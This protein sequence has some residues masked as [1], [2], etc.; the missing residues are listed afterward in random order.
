MAGCEGPRHRRRSR[1]SW[2]NTHHLVNQTISSANAPSAVPSAG[3]S[4]LSCTLSSANH[5]P[6]AP[7][8]MASTLGFSASA[9]ASASSAASSAPSCS[10]CSTATL[11]ALVCS[12]SAASPPSSSASAPSAAG[13]SAS[14]GS[15]A[16]GAAT[17]SSSASPYI[18]AKHYQLVGKD[19]DRAVQLFSQA[20]ASGD[21]VDSALKDLAIV[22]KQQNKADAAIAAVQ[23]LRHKCSDAAQESLDN[24]LLDLYKRCGR[25][26]D[27][28]ALLKHKLDRIRLGVAF[29]GRKTKTARSQGRKFQVSLEQEATRLLGNLGWAYMQCTNYQA[30]EFVY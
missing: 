14:T 23:Q 28:I 29:N 8:S 27:Q 16:S 21:R 15:A 30:A 2:Q 19:P 25:V 6:A 11:P 3:S 12:S 13:P 26:E 24:I 10:S 17:W 18:Q 9:S 7:P 20:I 1:K 5:K 22:L 4:A